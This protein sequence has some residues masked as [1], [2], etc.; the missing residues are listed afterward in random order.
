MFDIYGKM[1]LQIERIGDVWLIYRLSIA[2]VADLGS[3]LTVCL[4][5]TGDR[6]D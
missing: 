4:Q 3:S 6:N 5:W 1:R 2:D